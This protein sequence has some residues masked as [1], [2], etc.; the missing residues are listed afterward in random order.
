LGSALMFDGYF[1]FTNR[2][3]AYKSAR[4]YDEYSVDARS[5]RAEQKL[6]YKGYLGRPLGP[7]FNVEKPSE[8]LQ[9]VLYSKPTKASSKAWRRD[10]ENG[11][12]LVNP[13]DET[14]TV[15]LNGSFRK[16]RGKMD[17]AFN[18]GSVINEISLSPNS[19]AILLRAASE[20]KA[21]AE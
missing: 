9:S 7:A 10:Y 20:I 21:P 17:P 12:V 19:G 1:C 14:R 16:I 3:G 18:D 5:G 4:W 15:K 6:E 8:S 11:I 13:D 2:T